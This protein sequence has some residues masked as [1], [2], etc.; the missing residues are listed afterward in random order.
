MVE[1]ISAQT[2][3]L[4]IMVERAQIAEVAPLLMLQILVTA[5]EV[6]PA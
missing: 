4:C 3:I 2:A 6:S 5:K 1:S